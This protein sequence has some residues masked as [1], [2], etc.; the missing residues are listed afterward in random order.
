MSRRPDAEQLAELFAS[1]RLPFDDTDDVKASAARDFGR[2]ASGRADG[3]VRPT[4]I[5][6][7]PSLVELARRHGL[8]L[9]V[10]GAGLS[11]SGQSVARDGIV[12]DMSGLCAIDRPD[13][14]RSTIRCEP[15][16]TW[17]ALVARLAPLGLLP[18]VM[19]LNLDLTVGGTLSAGGLGSTSHLHGL[20]VSNVA[21]VDVVLATGRVVS[22]SPTTERAVFDSVLGGLGRGGI[23]RSVVLGLSRVPA[24]V[25]TFYLRYDDLDAMLADQRMIASER[26]ADHL[27]GYCCASIHGLPR[28]PGGR[29]QPLRRWGY[30]L[31]LSIG[32]DGDRVPSADAALEGLRHD[33]LMLADD[34]DLAPFAARYDVRFEAMRATGGWEQTHPWLEAFVPFDAAAEVIRRAQQ[35]PAFLGDGHRIIPIAERDHPLAVALPERTPIVVL[36]ILPMGVPAALHTLALDALRALDEHLAA[37][38][39]KRYLSGWLFHAARESGWKEHYGA[40]Y[41]RL[42]SLQ[43]E[44]DPARVFGSCLPPL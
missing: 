11:Q 39:A 16:A 12:V 33:E 44:H 23:I 37:V 18:T 14:E 41:D 25:R 10:R 40:A 13:L 29:R 1:A 7:L 43:R 5:D 4:H 3:V 35:L 36:A 32:F 27:E 26:R 21:S 22:A 38:G 20:S 17:R 24:K 8:S 34:D 28:G 2:I 15:G 19:P 9:T 6:Q 42:A 31:H 30:G